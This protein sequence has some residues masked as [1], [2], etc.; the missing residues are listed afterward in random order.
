[1]GGDFGDGS[2]K[3][4]MKGWSVTY[5]VNDPR[6]LNILLNFGNNKLF[7]T[8]NYK[9]DDFT[10]T[11]W[12][13]SILYKLYE[14]LSSD[15]EPGDLCFIVR[16]MMP[17]HTETISLINYV[18][19]EIDGIVLRSPNLN[20]IDS[21]IGRGETYYKSTTDILTSDTNVSEKLEN[22]FLSGS[23]SSAKLNIDYSQFENFIN[24]SSAEQRIKNFYY[25]LQQIENNN[26]LSSSL[27]VHNNPATSSLTTQIQKYERNIRNYITKFDGFENYMY[28]NSSSYYSSSLGEFYDNAWPKVSG[29]GIISDPYI[30]A[31]TSSLSGNN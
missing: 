7:L 22:E 30:L 2:D 4:P 26:I 12:P 13:H 3:Y 9:K 25:K 28:Y 15:I 14:P 31:L 16:E 6:E 29:S 23:F 1:L 20:S 17:P 8:V 19:N 10:V 11:K 21:P 5:K 27:A 18:K 24:F